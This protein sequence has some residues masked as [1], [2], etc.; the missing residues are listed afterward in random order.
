[1]RTIAN[2]LI[3]LVLSFQMRIYKFLNIIL[4]LV[5]NSVASLVTFNTTGAAIPLLITTTTKILKIL[6]RYSGIFLKL[7]PPHLYLPKYI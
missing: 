3:H 7:T 5:F 4:S 6:F 1:M 2:Y